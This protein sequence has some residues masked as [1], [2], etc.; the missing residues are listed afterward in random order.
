MA[1][2][3]QCINTAMAGGLTRPEAERVVDTLLADR[4]R[5][6]RAKALGN[7]DNAEQTL[8][9]VWA[10]RMEG[11]RI[12]QAAARKQAAINVL[13]RQRLNARMEAIRAAGFSSMDALESVLVGSNKRFFGA[14][15]SIDARRTGIRK[16]FLGG[17]INELEALDAQ[18][19]ALRGLLKNDPDFNRNVVSELYSPGVTKDD[20]ARAVA[21]IFARHMEKAR[22]RSNAAGAAIGRLDGYIPQSHDPWKLARKRKDG[23]SARQAWVEF[24]AD[25]L[26]P[27]RT[28]AGVEDEAERIRI[29]NRVYDNINMGREQGPNA[30]ERGER[31]S[32]ANLAGRLGAH[33]VLHFKDADAF[34]AY[35]AEYGRGNVLTGVLAHLDSASRNIALM[36]TLG[37]NPEAML[38]SVIAERVRLLRESAAGTELAPEQVQAFRD[39]EKAE[40]LTG[41]KAAAWF[42]ELTGEANWPTNLSAAR[43]WAAARATQTLSKLE[44][45]ACQSA[46]K[47][48]PPCASK[49]DPPQ[50]F[51]FKGAKWVFG[52]GGEER[53]S[54]AEPLF[55]PLARPY[56]HPALCERRHL[57]R[58][59][60]L[61]VSRMSQWCVTRSSRAVVIL[62]SP[63]TCGHSPKFRFVVIISDTCS[64][65]LDMA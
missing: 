4:A 15:D 61:P 45:A 9:D 1:T 47:N 27:E 6:E 53:R 63:K 20:T 60:S 29:L 54:V 44:G 28:F 25:K 48:D 39:L 33:R 12:I 43:F 62:A 32:P 21:D 16:D 24:I 8:A 10:R 52:E 17:V 40:G 34:M 49:N 22:Q 13:V 30:I 57:S 35:H 56:S 37:P 59:L 14:R 11:E 7:I 36:E 51:M 65:S 64:Y 26:D 18:G 58:R 55:S 42:S 46:L 50:V 38:K 5:V 23:R 31:S 3:A 2:K 41:G 19:A